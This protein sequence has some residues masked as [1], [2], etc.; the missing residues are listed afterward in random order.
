MA[1]VDQSKPYL[2]FIQGLV[3]EANPLNYPENATQIEQNFRLD[4]DGSRTRRLGLEQ[5]IGYMEQL[6][7]TDVVESYRWIDVGNSDTLVAVAVQYGSVIVIY[8]EDG[9]DYTEVFRIDLEDYRAAAG[10]IG[11]EPVSFDSGN[12]K[13]F[14]AEKHIQPIYI[15]YVTPGACLLD[16]SPDGYSVSQVQ[17]F[18]RDFDGV[19]DGLGNKD[20][21]A[22][23]TDAHRYNL[24]NQGWTQEYIDKYFAEAGVYPSNSE[25][26]YLG[27]YVDPDSGEELWSVEE[28]NKS[29]NQTTEAPRGHFIRNVF[30]T[31]DVFA[32][33]VTRTPASATL[34]GD[35]STVTVVF[36]TPHNYTTGDV[37]DITGSVVVN[38][39]TPPP[40]ATADV[41]DIY[42]YDGTR[43]VTV[44]DATT[45]TIPSMFVI[46][47]PDNYNVTVTGNFTVPLGNNITFPCCQEQYRPEVVAFYASRVWYTG[48]ESQRIGNRVYFSQVLSDDAKIGRNYQQNDPTSE[49]YNELLKN[50]GGF[51]DI[52]EM[53]GVLG[54]RVI[55]DS[56][57][58]FASN[59]IWSVSGTSYDFF[60]ADGY[61]ISK[62]T[63]VGCVSVKSIESVED[64]V[65]Y[66]SDRGIYVLPSEGRVTSI[67]EEAIHRRYRDIPS[68]CKKYIDIVYSKYDKVFHVLHSLDSEDPRRYCSE[69]LLN[70]R[71]GSWYQYMY[72]GSH[73]P[74]HAHITG[75]S[76]NLGR[77]ILYKATTDSESR[78]WYMVNCYY[79]DWDTFDNVDAP[80]YMKSGADSLGVLNR[81][82]S[83]ESVVFYVRGEPDTSLLYRFNWN[84][85]TDEATGAIGAVK[86]GFKPTTQY[87]SGYGYDVVIT[88]DKVRGSGYANAI[89]IS[90]E[91]DKP[92]TVYG[93]N[94]EY[95][96]RTR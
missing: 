32:D 36:P 62:L 43:T 38:T 44:I 80:A 33:Y 57:M 11:S 90:S 81:E 89:E 93:W 61:T 95:S 75:D 41:T 37:V 56:L 13:L 20:R 48:I 18:E 55:R 47:N 78:D 39:Y 77:D 74:A 94:I 4:P 91:P 14:I 30:D 1:K 58:L 6:A 66:A 69:L 76:S 63:D 65:V 84:W 46:T 42:S 87:N 34:S 53:A 88:R 71:M 70:Q 92:L 21:P 59:G 7:N 86:Q 22:T 23:L 40:P 45:V 27:N 67:T 49:D 9:H 8:E 85:A 73:K 3:T 52:P 25:Y 83:I 16:A 72:T 29:S 64:S 60:S 12:G 5:H 2:S 28:L 68:E 50:D 54:A 35:F 96:A 10:V 15:N 51:I 26:W 17:L 19:P 31:C 79:R 24:L 82:K